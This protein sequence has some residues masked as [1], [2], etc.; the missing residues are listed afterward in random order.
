M[1]KNEFLKIIFSLPIILVVFYFTPFLGIVMLIARKFVIGS[2]KYPL[3][4][5][6]LVITG[7][8]VLPR[9]IDYLI[10]LFKI[11]EPSFI[12]NIISSDIYGVLFA[13]A[14]ILFVIGI[15]AVVI[16]SLTRKIKNTAASTIKSY[17]S[18][19]Q[20]NDP[21]TNGGNDLLTSEKIERVKKNKLVRCPNCGASNVINGD[22]GKC[23]FCKSN[24]ENN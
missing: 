11:E 9:F 3:G 7:I 12:E 17:F 10:N 13:R 22:S 8:I 14:K 18:S 21:E 5:I 1:Y 23:A 20:Q 2:S 24:L 16:N 15:I 4:I 6:L 19:M